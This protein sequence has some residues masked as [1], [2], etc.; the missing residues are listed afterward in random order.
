MGG[1]NL[2]CQSLPSMVF[3]STLDWDGKLGVEVYV[4]GEEKN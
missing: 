4:F 1:G 3:A 2:C